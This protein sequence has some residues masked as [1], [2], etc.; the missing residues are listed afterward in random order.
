ERGRVGRPW[1]AHPGVARIPGRAS[2]ADGRHAAG[3]A[4]LPD[5]KS[6]NS[7]YRYFISLD[8][9]ITY[10]RGP[11]SR[12]PMNLQQFRFVR[13]TIRRDFNLTEA[14]RMLYTSQ[15]GVSKAII[16]FEDELG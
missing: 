7:L 8:F 2:L 13:E 4:G 10:N 6:R 1:P 9:L 12:S 3:E 16:E 15:P 14:A 5:G 11:I